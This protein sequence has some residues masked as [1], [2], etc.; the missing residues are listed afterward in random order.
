MSSCN[1]R[2]ATGPACMDKL[3]VGKTGVIWRVTGDLSH[4][5]PSCAQLPHAPIP[6]LII[7]PDYFVHSWAGVTPLFMHY[8]CQIPPT[9]IIMNQRELYSSSRANDILFYLLQIQL[10][11]CLLP[12]PIWSFRPLVRGSGAAHDITGGQTSDWARPTALL[13]LSR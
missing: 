12:D 9:M 4:F 11:R 13:L 5:V 10:Y 7:A 3:C 1:D 8:H 6:I 2:V